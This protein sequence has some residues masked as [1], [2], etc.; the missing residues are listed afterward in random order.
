MQ[1]AM[2]SLETKSLCLTAKEMVKNNL[3]PPY[4]FRENENADFVRISL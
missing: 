2:A 3:P 1:V 4:D